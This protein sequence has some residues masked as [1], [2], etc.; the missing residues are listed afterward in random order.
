MSTD[1]ENKQPDGSESESA[2]QSNE[3]APAEEPGD[4]K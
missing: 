4:L 3:E 2:D 1:E